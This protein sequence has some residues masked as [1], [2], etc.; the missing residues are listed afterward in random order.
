[1]SILI[2]L[3]IWKSSYA[4]PILNLSKWYDIVHAGP[5][6]KLHVNWEAGHF[7]PAHI[8]VIDHE[9]KN[10]VVC[11]RGTLSA[12]DAIS[13]A[14]CAYVDFQVQ[15]FLSQ[16]TIRTANATKECWNVPEIRL[17]RSKGPS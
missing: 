5:D 7:S 8:V 9:R 15:T 13:D 17:L 6:I 2:R 3:S 4:I 1:M 16:L 10:L 12:P 11:I 14:I